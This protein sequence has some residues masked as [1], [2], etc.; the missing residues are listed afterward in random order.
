MPEADFQT[1]PVRIRNVDEMR[2]VNNIRV[3]RLKIKLNLLCSV[4]SRRICTLSFKISSILILHDQT[5]CL[6]LHILQFFTKY[7]KLNF[8]FIKYHGIL[9]SSLFLIRSLGLRRR[10][11]DA[12]RAM[13]RAMLGLYDYVIK[14][15]M[16]R[17]VEEQSYRHSSTSLKAEVAMGGHI[18]RR[19]DGRWGPNVQK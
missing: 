12:Q 9:R 1:L 14:S 5:V 17:S 16:W 6:S 18:V 3:L 7:S 2:F 4:N 13:E 15:E 19:K 8:I 11:R 10:L